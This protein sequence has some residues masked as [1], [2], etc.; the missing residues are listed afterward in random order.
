MAISNNALVSLENIIQSFGGYQN[1]RILELGDQKIRPLQNLYSKIY[2]NNKGIKKHVSFDL[3]GRGGSI[4]EDLSKIIPIFCYGLF[5]II[6]NF[7]TLEH[8][9]EQYTVFLNIH[10]FCK[11]GGV[12]VHSLPLYGYWGRH[13]IYNYKL[14]FLL[15]IAN[16]CNYEVLFCD[17]RAKKNIKG[18]KYIF[19]I[20]AALKK[21]EGNQFIDREKFNLITKDYIVR[22]KK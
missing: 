6:T 5:D 18:R 17:A 20:V 14:E 21:R 19:L 4:K 9:K 12:M 16:A 11:V 8:I 1:V 15:K 13:G 7:G 3:N 10:N 2:F 22:N